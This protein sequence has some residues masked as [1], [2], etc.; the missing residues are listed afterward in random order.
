MMSSKAQFVVKLPGA[1]AE[2]LV[3]LGQAIYFDPGHGRIMKQWV[4]VTGGE[5]LWIPLAKEAHRFVE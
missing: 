3:R 1:R 2:E 5:S 4:V